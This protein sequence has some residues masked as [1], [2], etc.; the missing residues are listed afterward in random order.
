MSGAPLAAAL[1]VG[2]AGAGVVVAALLLR[3]GHGAL[4]AWTALVAWPVLLAAAA[5]APGPLTAEID[6]RFAALRVALR[7]ADVA[8]PADL[9]VLH[10]EMR[11]ADAKLA[12]VDRLLAAGPPSEAVIEARGRAADDVRAVLA[13]LDALRADLGLALLAGSSVVVGPRLSQLK[14]RVHTA[15]HMAELGRAAS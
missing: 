9:A 10:A 13:E 3:R 5:R 7:E 4:L 8:A 15:R 1:A 12:R 11:E 14:A 6:A 2:W